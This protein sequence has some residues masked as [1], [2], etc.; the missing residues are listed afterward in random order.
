MVL[1]FRRLNGDYP[2]VSL[3][4]WPPPQQQLLLPLPL[5]LLLQ[6]LIIRGTAPM[7]VIRDVD[8][9]WTPI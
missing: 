8:G 7:T 4:P 9:E 5:L 6:R 2:P 1:T 3:G